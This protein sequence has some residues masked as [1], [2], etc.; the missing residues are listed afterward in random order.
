[1]SVVLPLLAVAAVIEI[2]VTPLFIKL[3]IPYL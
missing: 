3:V 1:V 2:D